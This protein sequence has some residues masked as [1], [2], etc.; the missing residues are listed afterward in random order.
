MVAPVP[1]LATGCC[2]LQHTHP[3]PLAQ[4][5]RALQCCADV[6]ARKGSISSFFKPSP[7]KGQGPGGGAGQAAARNPDECESAGGAATAIGAKR[8][9]PAPKEEGSG[10]RSKMG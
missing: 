2:P 1:R 3:A 9:A 4:R 8:G 10:K 7:K 5:A 6:R